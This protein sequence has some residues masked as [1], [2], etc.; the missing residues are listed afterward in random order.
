MTPEIEMTPEIASFTRRYTDL[1]VHHL[2]EWGNGSVISNAAQSQYVSIPITVSANFV[3]M[4]Y[5]GIAKDMQYIV[6]TLN[7]HDEILQ[8]VYEIVK[9]IEVETRKSDPIHDLTDQAESDLHATLSSIREKRFPAPPSPE[10]ASLL[11]KA[12]DKKKLIR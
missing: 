11:T 12:L 8:E 9:V 4:P 7:R 10:I 6:T 3:F 5:E 2:G 1:I